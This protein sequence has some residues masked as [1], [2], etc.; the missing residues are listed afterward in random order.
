M[1]NH[2]ITVSLVNGRVSAVPNP[3]PPPGTTAINGNTVTWAFNGIAGEIHVGFEFAREM[4]G[5][6]LK[7]VGPMGPFAK[8]E[9]VGNQIIGTFG[10]DLDPVQGIWRYFC[11]FFL[12]GRPLPWDSA[13]ESEMFDGGIDVPRQPPP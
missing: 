1:P 8:I 9:R 3:V 10:Q 13:T 12:D 6:P 2:P 7:P 5:G 11:K 4:A